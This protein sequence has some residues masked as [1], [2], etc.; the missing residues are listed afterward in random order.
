MRYGNNGSLIS[1][2]GL[3]PMKLILQVCA[4]TAYRS[5]CR[6]YQNGSQKDIAHAFLA[7]HSL[8][9]TLVIAWRYACPSGGSLSIAKD[10]HIY[11]HLCYYRCCYDRI[12]SWYLLEQ[13]V[14]LP[15]RC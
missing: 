15:E 14:L 9:A 10:C 7:V 12:Y 13:L 8:A 2:P 4:L 3:E 11:P 6:L 5:S 1:S